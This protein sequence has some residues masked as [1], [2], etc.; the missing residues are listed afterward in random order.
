MPRYDSTF[1]VSV[2][3]CASHER[4]VE[5]YTPKPNY[6]S[7][8]GISSSSRFHLTYTGL[9]L[10]SL[11]TCTRFT[12][13]VT[14]H[15]LLYFGA[16]PMKFCSPWS[17]SGI[18]TKPPAEEKCKQ[19]IFPHCDTLFCCFEWYYRAINIYLDYVTTSLRNSLWN[20]NEI[21]FSSSSIAGLLTESAIFCIILH[22]LPLVTICHNRL[23]NS[24]LHTVRSASVHLE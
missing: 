15:C 6:W 18:P 9:A 4:F 22:V 23:Y 12:F 13:A 2:F 16:L 17:A 20:I 19:R 11:H 7:T 21:C 14:P 3:M 5:V 10:S 8:I 24:C 1:A